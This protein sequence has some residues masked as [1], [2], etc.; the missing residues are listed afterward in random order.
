MLAAPSGRP[1]GLKDGPCLER[2]ARMRIVIATPEGRYIAT[3]A[4]IERHRIEVLQFVPVALYPKG[5][6]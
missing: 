5:A 1:A 6:V 2:L 4:G 3:D